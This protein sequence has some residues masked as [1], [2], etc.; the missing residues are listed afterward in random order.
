MQHIPSIN[1]HIEELILHGFAREERYAIGE[2]LQNELQRL[3]TT[4]GLPQSFQ[5][6]RSHHVAQFHADNIVV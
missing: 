1:L 4:Q 3:F 6:D 5:E 2:A